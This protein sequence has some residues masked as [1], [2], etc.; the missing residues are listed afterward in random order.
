MNEHFS[1]ADPDDQDDHELM[2]LAERLFSSET[3][4]VELER[5]CMR[6]AHCVSDGAQQLLERFRQSPRAGAV[7]W[8]D[9]ALEEGAFHLLSPRNDL[10]EQEFLVLKVVEDIQETIVDLCMRR[11]EIDLQRRKLLVRQAAL[12]SIGADGLV[13]DDLLC[14][15]DAQLAEIDREIVDIDRRVVIEEA[16]IKRLRA[17]I[18]TPR[19]RAADPRLIRSIHLL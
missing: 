14:E 2:D 7:E 12:S 16:V 19:Y 18:T 10:E 1:S 17:S 5:I 15:V 11:D 13:A 9:C 6:L 8:L 4:V 3:P